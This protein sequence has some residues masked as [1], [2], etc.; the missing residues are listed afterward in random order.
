VFVVIFFMVEE[1]VILRLL[2]PANEESKI[3]LNL[4]VYQYLPISL[5]PHTRRFKFPATEL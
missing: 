5:M 1:T 3:L 2:N 4:H